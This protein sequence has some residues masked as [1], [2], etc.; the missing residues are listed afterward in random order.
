M[1]SG[2][3]SRDGI[4]ADD[5]VDWLAAH[6]VKLSLAVAMSFMLWVR[7]RPIDRFTGNDPLQWQAVDSY[8]HWR[9]TE[10]TVRNFPF[11]MP[12]DI[13]TGYPTGRIVGQFGTLFD[14]FIATLAMVIGL[15]SPGDSEILLAAAIGVPLIATA[16]AIPVFFIGRRLATPT[17]ALAGVIVLA[18]V[19]GEFLTRTTAGMFQHHAA[20]VLMMAV[21][22]LAMM[23]ALRVA[24]REQP[25]WE[26]LLD[27]DWSALKRPASYSAAAG[28]ALTMY[29]LVWPPAIILF[30]IFGVFFVVAITLQHVRGLSPE[31]IAFVAAIS[32]GTTA[33]TSVPM[34]ERWTFGSI[35]TFDLFIPFS[36]IAIVIAAVALG[37]LSRVWF[38]RGLTPTSYPAAVGSIG[39]VGIVAVWLVLP[40]VFSFFWSNLTSRVLPLDPSTGALTVAEA[41]PPDEIGEFFFDQFGL[42]FYT[43][44]I[45]LGALVARPF[46]G[47][48]YRV[49]HLLIIV[50]SL[51]LIS[52]ALTQIR[53]S[54]Y[55]V[56]AVA[57]VNAYLVGEVA[58]LVKFP[59]VSNLRAIKG[60]Q[61]LTVVLIIMVLFVPLVNPIATT[62]ALDASDRAHPSTD[63]LAWEESTTWLNEQTPPVGDWGEHSNA[64]EVDPWGTYRHPGNGYDYPDGSYGVM[65][66]WDYGH[67]ITTHGERIPHANP[68][69]QHA[70]SAATYLLAQSETIGN[71]HLDAIAATGSGVTTTDPD[72]LQAL[73]DGHEDE[74]DTGMRYVMIDDQMAAGNPGKLQAIV[75]WTDLSWDDFYEADE[76]E[77]AFT[78]QEVTAPGVSE[79]YESTMLHRLYF[80]DTAGLEHYRLVH[81]SERFTS[82]GTVDLGDGSAPM[83]N[84]RLQYPVAAL[85]GLS[86]LQFAQMQGLPV[87]DVRQESAVKTFERVEGAVLSGQAADPDALVVIEIEIETNADREFVYRNVVEPDDD[88]SFEVTVP[89][90]TEHDLSVED[91]YTEPAVDTGDVVHLTEVSGLN[92]TDLDAL[93]EDER[94]VEAFDEEIDRIGHAEVLESQVYD[95]E[96]VEV[97]L[98]ERPPFTIDDVSAPDEVATDETV[99]LT[100]TITNDGQLTDTQVVWLTEDGDRLDETALTLEPGESGEVTL[101]TSFENETT[102]TLVIETLADTYEHDLTVVNETADNTTEM[103]GPVSLRP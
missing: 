78:G 51:F 40:D 74:L 43:M 15:G 89:Y 76:F 59:S 98:T 18:L 44:L 101:Q 41:R 83:L 49:E 93:D 62:S 96:T 97:E 1:S 14:Q 94:V 84:T 23:V 69:Q 26:L 16:V 73:I 61:A 3:E 86:P 71:L 103:V 35:T 52:M 47:K 64:D 54:Y 95:G 22:I 85:G 38:A 31:P 19:P 34:I 75:Q 25:V 68:F 27:R 10:W 60:Y 28:L 9:A 67:L 81:E 24:E 8:Y 79:V 87:Y 11:T 36:A 65:S 48:D 77:D 13:F 90:A 72:E 82:F 39:V 17:A 57:V 102:T 21:S 99:N 4:S 55:L 20:E 70:R 53:F 29:A 37:W 80:D 30:G 56:L 32:L 58:E 33:I 92:A 42:A 100:V 12:Y 50:W 7:L 66:W 45:G 5:V 46:I 91:G 6:Y 2:T 88:G 63:G